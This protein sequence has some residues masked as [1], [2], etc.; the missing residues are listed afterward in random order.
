MTGFLLAVSRLTKTNALYGEKQM[1]TNK[2]LPDWDR[3]AVALSELTLE[4]GIG[5]EGAFAFQM[6]G[7]DYLFGYAVS[8]DGK[9]I[10]C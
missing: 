5:L 6:E 2:S 1:D 7:D 10:R 4:Y 9:V 3:F 8:D